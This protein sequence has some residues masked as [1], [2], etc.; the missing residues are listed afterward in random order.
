MELGMNRFEL[1][2]YDEM[3]DVVGGKN[4]N[5]VCYGILGMVTVVAAVTT[6][7]VTLPLAAMAVGGSIVSGYLVGTGLRP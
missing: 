4:W 1:L 7:P 6:A 2:S 5:D 3:L